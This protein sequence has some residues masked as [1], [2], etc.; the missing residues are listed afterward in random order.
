MISISLVLS[1]LNIISLA[2]VNDFTYI[3]GNTMGQNN[4][5]SKAGLLGQC[6]VNYWPGNRYYA[7]SCIDQNNQIFYL[8]GGSGYLSIEKYGSLDDL[9]SLNLNSQEWCWLKGS[10]FKDNISI[11]YGV[12]NEVVSTVNPGGRS[13]AVS[14]FD[15]ISNQL[16]MFSGYGNTL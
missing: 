5:L 15:S 3:G 10:P 1:L 6:S 2:A 11:N 14:F 12:L 9:W 16:Y 7:T 8:F 13:G 4:A